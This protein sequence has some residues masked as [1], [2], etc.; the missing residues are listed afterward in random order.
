MQRAQALFT[1]SGL[2]AMRNRPGD[3]RD[4][5]R[6]CQAT[7]VELGARLVAAA[8]MEIGGVT[9]LI[10]GDPEAADR[11]VADG[12]ARLEGLGASGYLATHRAIQSVALARSGRFERALDVAARATAE[13]SQEDALLVVTYETAR[14]TAFL[15][16]GQTTDALAAAQ[17][18]VSRAEKTDWVSYHADA[19]LALAAAHRARGDEAEAR[20]A[21]TR[22][23]AFYRAKQHLPGE[24]RASAFLVVSSSHDRLLAMW[25]E[26]CGRPGSARTA[27]RL[28]TRRR[29]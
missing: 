27:A 18:A 10:I 15:G 4:A 16:L 23:L 19:L 24:E 25:R 17:A 26:Q 1:L 22:A 21:A 7:L 13:G 28:W 29:R 20:T 2:Y 3:A 12:V 6:T 9:E 5:Y 14:A 11:W 8:T